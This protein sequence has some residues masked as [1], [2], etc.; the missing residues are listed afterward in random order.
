SSTPS[1][2]AWPSTLSLHD[3]L[4]IFDGGDGFSCLRAIRATGLRH[5]GATA[6]ALPAN[7]SR[8]GAD[9]I[10]SREAVLD[11]IGDTDHDAGLAVFRDRKSTR[12]NSSHVKIS[13]AVFCL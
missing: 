2:P 1:S 5:I 7:C 13:Y 11:V 10:D 3:A 8:G 6:A 12:L 4:P 9:Q